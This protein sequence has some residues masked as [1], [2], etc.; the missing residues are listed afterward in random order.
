M[1]G[2]PYTMLQSISVA[3]R[4]VR[5]L[6]SMLTEDD[7][8]SFADKHWKYICESVNY[9]RNS[10]KSAQWHGFERRGSAPGPPSFGYYDAK[11]GAPTRFDGAHLSLASSR[12][13]VFRYLLY[14]CARRGAAPKASFLARSMAECGLGGY[15]AN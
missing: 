12:C 8:V 3:N 1:S 13:K 10:A 7:L 2:R 9:S 11:S 6:R 15:R 14:L 4:H 5:T